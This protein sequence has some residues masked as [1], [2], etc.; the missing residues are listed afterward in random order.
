MLGHVLRLTEHGLLFAGPPRSLFVLMPA[1][2]QTRS[3]SEFLGDTSNYKVRM[4]SLIVENTV[5]FLMVASERG[6]CSVVEQP[7]SSWMCKQASMV[8]LAFAGQCVLHH[9]VEGV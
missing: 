4:A 2:V 5:V 3:H 6:A 8:D 9:R 1:S 7:V